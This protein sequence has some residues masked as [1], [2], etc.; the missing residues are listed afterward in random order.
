M[1]FVAYLFTRALGWPLRLDGSDHA[2]E[3]EILVLRHQ[4]RA[5][6]RTTP[7][8]RLSGV[9][10]A[11]FGALSRILPRVADADPP[12]IRTY[13]DGVWTDNLLALPRY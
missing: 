6:R 9:D 7:R 11:V 12:D 3:L 4:L 13:A 2:N 10:R 1:A 8:P 5:L